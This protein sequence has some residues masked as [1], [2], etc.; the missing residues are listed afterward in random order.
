MIGL[1]RMNNLQMS[2]EQVLAGDLI[3]TGVWRGGATLFKRGV[4]KAH[5]VTDRTV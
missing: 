1:C 4:L 2:S 3:E 5:G